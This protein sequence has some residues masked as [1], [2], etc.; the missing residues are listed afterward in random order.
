MWEPRRLTTLLAS[1]AYCVQVKIKVILRQTVGQSVLVSGHH[2][3]QE[4]KFSFSTTEIIV[5]YLNILWG[6]LS[7]E[8]TGL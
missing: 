8:S 5:R 3:G 4:T 6:A 7:D 2:L 1:K